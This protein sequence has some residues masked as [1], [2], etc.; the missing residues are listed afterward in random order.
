MNRIAQS[1]HNGVNLGASAASTDPDA[2]IFLILLADAFSVFYGFRE[3]PLSAPAL[4]L[5]ALIYV[6]SMLI[7][8]RSASSLNSWNIC[9]ISPL[10]CHSAN[11]LYTVC[12]GPYR[13]GRSRQDAPLRAIQKIPFSMSRGSFLGLPNVP[14]CRSGKYFL[15]RSHSSSVSS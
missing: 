4:A 2:L 1:V 8:S 15:S 13:S 14:G 10:F 11:R 7:H 6:L 5:C 12:H 3:P 9:S